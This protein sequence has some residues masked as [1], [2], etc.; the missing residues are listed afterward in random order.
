MPQYKLINPVMKGNMNTTVKAKDELAAANKMWQEMSQYFSN[1]VPKFAFSMEKASG[2]VS[3]FMVKES[4]KNNDNAS[5]EIS[6]LSINLSKANN[7]LFK[8]RC[9]RAQNK[10]VGGKKKHNKDDESS[11]EDDIY[12]IIAKKSASLVTPIH[13]VWYDPYIYNF[14]SVYFPTF[15]HPWT[16][17]VELTTYYW[18][19]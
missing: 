17:Y 3:H 15:V 2:G 16:P 18:Y 13:Y 1:N 6:E 4:L 19:P 7:N 11:S 5:Y 14:D 9:G 10:S 12:D 8:E